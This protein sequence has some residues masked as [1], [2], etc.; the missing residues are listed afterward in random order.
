MT[1]PPAAPLPIRVLGRALAGAVA[2]LARVRPAP[3]VMHPH[4]EVRTGRLRRHGGDGA[5]SGADFLDGSGDDE[6]LVRFSRAAGL[7]AP[8][9]DV[10]GL[11]L[12]IPDGAGGH[13]DLLLSTTGRGRLARFVLV[14]TLR[15]HGAFQSMLLP[16]RSPTGP[17]LVAASAAG[18]DRWDLLWARPRGPWTTFA[19][20]E[21]DPLPGR[22]LDLSFDAVT[23][24]PAGLE[25]YEWH[26]RLR[27]PSYAA[28][29]ASRATP[30]P[31]AAAAPAPG[32]PATD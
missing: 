2:G 4:G 20:L 26:R 32:R 18:E 11:A 30:A 15:E 31:P 10:D 8:W 12:R 24:A 6:V 14:P 13:A 5:R 23:A 29:R 1:S 22:D 17:V 25:V 7:P 9:P 21:V 28:S 16:H 19:T 3:K 27:E